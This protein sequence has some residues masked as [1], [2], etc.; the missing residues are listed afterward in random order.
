[1]V[2]AH[3]LQVKCFLSRLASVA[4]FWMTFGRRVNGACEADGV[5]VR[6]VQGRR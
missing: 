2:C 1:M 6:Q 3:S 5:C 4:G